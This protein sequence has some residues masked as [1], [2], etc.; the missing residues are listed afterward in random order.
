[1]SS[2]PFFPSQSYCGKLLSWSGAIIGLLMLAQL[3]ALAD[4]NPP[5]QDPPR[6]GTGSSGVVLAN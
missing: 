1:M 2:F 5:D 3:P 6:G 4:Y